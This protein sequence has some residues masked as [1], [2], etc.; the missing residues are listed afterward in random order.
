MS[1]TKDIIHLPCLRGRMGDWL[2]YVTLMSFAEVGKR[3]KLPHEIDEKYDDEKLKLGDWIQRKI[4][5]NRTKN[6]VDYLI[7]TE[8]RFFNSLI[9]GLYDGNPTWQ[10]VDV[11][12]S[13]EYNDEDQLTYLS[14]T[15]GILSLHGNESIFAIDGQHRALS[16]RKAIQEDPSLSAD[17]IS[18]IFIAHKT[19]EVGKIRTRR[20]FSTLNKYAKPVSQSEIIALSE[21]NNCSIITRALVDEFDILAGKVLVIKNRSISPENT[22]AFTNIMVLYDIVERLLTDKSI[23]GIK[24]TGKNKNSYIK[25]RVS[26]AEID[27]DIKYVKKLL[28]EVISAIPSL[29]AFFANGKVNRAKKGT[30][31]LFRP[32]GQNILFNTLKVAI[33]QAKKKKALDY[34]SKDTFNLSNKVWNKIF[35][36]SETNTIITEKSRQRFA[37]LLILE[38][39]GFE[40]KRTKKDQQVFDSFKIQPKDI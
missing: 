18:V 33:D 4:E 39:L 2:Y 37:T 27:S 7:R 16:I 12:T 35:W 17:E 19:D 5:K 9:L 10:E 23:A 28:K 15:F 34:F 32:I 36:D 11:Q 6:I 40:A 1:K 3:V 30:S 14:K 22:S 8:Q 24:V 29:A 38:H 20:L 21:D 31:L 13:A 25:N 26:D